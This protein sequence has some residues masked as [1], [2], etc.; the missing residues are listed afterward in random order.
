MFGILYLNWF[1]Y[2]EFRKHHCPITQLGIIP[3]F[4]YPVWVIQC[5]WA[6]LATVHVESYLLK[7]TSVMAVTAQHMNIQ[8]SNFILI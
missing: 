5:R 3:P 4:F 1:I 2:L 6:T 8:C 7:G